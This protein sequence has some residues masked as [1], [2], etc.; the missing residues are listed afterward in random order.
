FTSWL[1]TQSPAQ[2]ASIL[3][4]VSRTGGLADLDS[5]PSAVRERFATSLAVTPAWH[6]RMQA[7]FQ[8]FTD[9]GVSKT[10]NFPEN[11]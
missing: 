1:A 6:V 10:T 2:A 8:A 5:V 3:Q 4:A 7:A 9:N 11:A